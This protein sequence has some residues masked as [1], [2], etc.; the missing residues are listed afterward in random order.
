MWRKFQKLPLSDD[1]FG[2]IE[3]NVPPYMK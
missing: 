3:R 1:E 2:I